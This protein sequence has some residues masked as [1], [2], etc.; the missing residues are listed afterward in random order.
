MIESL[1]NKTEITKKTHYPIL[2]R[3]RGV[4]GEICLFT[5]KNN[6]IILKS[7]SPKLIGSKL[8]TDE[9]EEFEIFE[10][11]LILTSKNEAIL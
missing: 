6:Y 11:E 5:D 7:E 9:P 3:D 1:P 10:G 8:Y 4:N 2:K